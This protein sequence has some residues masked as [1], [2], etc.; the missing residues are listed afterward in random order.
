MIKI[1]IQEALIDKNMDLNIFHVMDLPSCRSSSKHH[2]SQNVRVKD[3][4][5]NQ[6]SK[7]S[8]SL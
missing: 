3:L 1:Y 6:L 7:P 4:Q 5:G 2:I 8:Y